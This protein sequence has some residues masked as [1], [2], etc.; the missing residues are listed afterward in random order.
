MPTSLC[1]S[2]SQST[3][4]VF[5]Y[6]APGGPSMVV[7]CS[8]MSTSQFGDI[9]VAFTGSSTAATLITAKVI[10]YNSQIPPFTYG[11]QPFQITSWT[12]AT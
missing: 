11:T 9:T 4:N 7:A 10:F 1:L 5:T 3:S 12:D 2:A 8:W 6:Q